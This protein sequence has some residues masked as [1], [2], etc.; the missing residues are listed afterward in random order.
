MTYNRSMRGRLDQVQFPFLAS[1]SP[2]A[3]TELTGLAKTHARPQQPLLR[4]GDA[5]S[6]AYLVLGGSLRVY[7]I[8]AQGREATLYH[9][10][11]GATCVL[12]LTSAFNAEPYPAWV[13]AGG[14]GCD[15][16]CVPNLA[17]QRLLDR[18]QAFRA[19]VFSVMS[20]RIFELMQTLQETASSQVEQR[21]ARYLVKHAR[22][23]TRELRVSQVGIASELGTAR[24]VVFRALRSLVQRKLIETGRMR[25]RILDS[26]GLARLATSDE[27][28][29][30]REGR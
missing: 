6:G 11:P 13:D 9:V 1:L 5:V 21:V 20:G 30:R 28:F 17:L 18:E 15:F 27:P 19:F 23:P 25:I 3:R 10:E 14:T 24:E 4:Q 16:V 29:A 2:A 22:E 12:A 8:T 7:F 26:D